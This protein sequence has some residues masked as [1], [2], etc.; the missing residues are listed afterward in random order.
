MRMV[1]TLSVGIVIPFVVG[2]VGSAY[3]G[4]KRAT[5]IGIAYA[6]LAGGLADQAEAHPRG[7]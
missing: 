5:A 2:A 3:S 4:I 1:A 6:A 7:L